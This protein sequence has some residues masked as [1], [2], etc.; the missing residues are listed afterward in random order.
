M[1]VLVLAPRLSSLRCGPICARLCAPKPRR[2]ATVRCKFLTCFHFV[3][4]RRPGA[5]RLERESIISENEMKFISIK[6]FCLSFICIALITLTLSIYYRSTIDNTEI[7][8]SIAEVVLFPILLSVI[9][10]IFIFHNDYKKRKLAKESIN[11][12]IAIN[13][14]AVVDKERHY[15]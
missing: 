14:G 13:L 1:R 11:A 7:Y 8:K 5:Q 6:I 15:A 10:Q 9:G 12:C 2:Q 4:A 3:F